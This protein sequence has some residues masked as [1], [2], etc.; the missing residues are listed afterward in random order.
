MLYDQSAGNLECGGS[1]VSKRLS[2]DGYS[3]GI[4]AGL[5]DRV[6]NLDCCSNREAC[7]T[8][9][10]L[11]LSSLSR[12]VTHWAFR[13][14]PPPPKPQILPGALEGHV[15]GCRLYGVHHNPRLK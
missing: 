3:E 4:P 7:L 6:V 13:V 15:Q 12:N 10:Y 14:C 11:S 9:T 8:G 1:G 5:F 2:L